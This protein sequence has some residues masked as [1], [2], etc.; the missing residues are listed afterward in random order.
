M[1]YYIEI[2]L[3][4]KVLN[5][6]TGNVLSQGSLCHVLIH[7]CHVL[8]VLAVTNHGDKI[9]VMN[10]GQNLSLYKHIKIHIQIAYFHRELK[11][12]MYRLHAFGFRTSRMNSLGPC[13]EV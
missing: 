3:E 11:I 1:N 12:Y 10:P 9:L 2:S 5:L 13:L 6:Y 7:K 8:P 4:L